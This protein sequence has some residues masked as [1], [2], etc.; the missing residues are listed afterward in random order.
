MLVWPSAGD[1]VVNA[2]FRRQAAWRRV[3][4]APGS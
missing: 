2:S 3:S 4:T 1:G